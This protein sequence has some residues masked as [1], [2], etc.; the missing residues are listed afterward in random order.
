ML[1]APLARKSILWIIAAVFAPLIGCSVALAQVAASSGTA[2]PAVA[3]AILDVE[4]YAAKAGKEPEA[5]DDVFLMSQ[6]AITRLSAAGPRALP[7]IH[8]VLADSSMDWKVKAMMCEALGKINT[9]ESAAELSSVLIDKSQHEFVRAV[10]GDKLALWGRPETQDLIK[11]IVSDKSVPI[12]IR[13]RT[14]MSVGVTGHDD[15]EWLKL[16]AV[17]DGLGL[18]TDKHEEISQDEYGLILNAQRALGKSKNPRALDIILEL[19][20]KYPMNGIYTEILQEKRDPKSIPTLLKVLTYKNPKGFTSDAMILAADALG[21]MRA[22]EAA[23]PL[24]EIIVED[25]NPLFVLAAAKALV[26][27]D[28]DRARPIVK[29]LVE[30][31]G[32]DERFNKTNHPNFWTEEQAGWGPIVELKRLSNR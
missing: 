19:Q 10:A 14:M 24:S 21:E 23:E 15:I 12:R 11:Q 5:V 17:G 25:K 7:E 28:A 29:K 16:L 13:E 4:G 8:G 20:E 26:K 27:I 2:D 31:L 22:R 9:P 30:G 1:V 6:S 32:G 18:P 3:K